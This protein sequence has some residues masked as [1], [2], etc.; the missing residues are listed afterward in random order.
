MPL[1]FVC[2]GDSE[3]P[4]TQ[5]SSTET[6]NSCGKKM[7]PSHQVSMKFIFAEISAIL[8]Q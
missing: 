8:R 5:G 3:A 7:H 1:I 6:T 4:Y 2:Q